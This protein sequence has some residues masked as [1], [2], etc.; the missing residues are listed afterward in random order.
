V[1]GRNRR[2]TRSAQRAFVWLVAGGLG[3]SIAFGLTDWLPGVERGIR[4][5]SGLSADAVRNA[6]GYEIKLPQVP[7]P[8]TDLRRRLAGPAFDAFARAVHAGDRYFVD[9][10]SGTHGPFITDAEVVRDYL[11]Y[12]LLPAVRVTRLR[13]AT[14]IVRYRF[15]G[16]YSVRRL[17]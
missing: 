7:P 6:P 3:L 11:D 15:D 14:V 4:D 2:G 16:T 13:D 1:E 12:Y 8:G 9:V 10:P 17:R 5:N